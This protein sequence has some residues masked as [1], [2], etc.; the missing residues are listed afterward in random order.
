MK[1]EWNDLEIKNK[2][3]YNKNVSKLKRNEVNKMLKAKRILRDLKHNLKGT[4]TIFDSFM[5][6]LS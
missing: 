1:R 6:E 5:L 4:K 3:C 2:I